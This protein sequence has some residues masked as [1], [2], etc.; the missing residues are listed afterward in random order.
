MEKAGPLLGVLVC[1]LNS[2]LVNKSAKWGA[3]LSIKTVPS[4]I[5]RWLWFDDLLESILDFDS[6]SK[7]TS[8]YFFL[9]SKLIQKLKFK[10]LN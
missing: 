2:I 4:K 3:I 9:E 7:K 6:L 8:L 5:E 10:H 1:L